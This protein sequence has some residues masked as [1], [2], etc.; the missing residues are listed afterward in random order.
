[1]QP[2][3]NAV[4]KD[5]RERETFSPDGTCRTYTTQ[6]GDDDWPAV[7]AQ[8]RPVDDL[9]PPTWGISKGLTKV[10][11]D[12]VWS[13]DGQRIAFVSQNK[14]SDD[15]WIAQAKD[16]TEQWNLT[17]NTW[18][19]DKHPSWGPDSQHI[20]FWSN[21]EGTKQ[22]FIIDA[23]NLNDWRKVS[24]TTWDEYDPIWIK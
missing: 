12:P 13:P 3:M 19:W 2:D 7:Y 24:A 6:T 16:G 1:M 17:P 15:I 21:R 22:I 10:N 8:C 18:E 14:G 20:V 5:L 4:Y 23:D 11:Y 9:A